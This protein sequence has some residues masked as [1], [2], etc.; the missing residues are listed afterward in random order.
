MHTHRREPDIP[1]RV[2]AAWLSCRLNLIQKDEYLAEE[3]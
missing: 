1:H 2:E 3:D